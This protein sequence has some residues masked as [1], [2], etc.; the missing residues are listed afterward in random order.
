MGKSAQ[1][2]ELHPE[3]RA[4]AADPLLE[5][6]S[7]LQDDLSRLGAIHRAHSDAQLELA[8]L[9]REQRQIDEREAAEWTRW[10]K[11]PEGPPPR[12]LIE[13]REAWLSVSAASNLSASFAAEATRARQG[14]QTSVR[15]SR[16]STTSC[17][18]QN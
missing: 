9:D 14:S 15:R 1:V 4:Q 5:R 7:E 6:R 10:A 2:V 16:A 8:A 3:P 17:S 18:S 11:A 12:P 13:Q